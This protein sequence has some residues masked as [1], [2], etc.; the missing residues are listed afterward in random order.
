[1]VEYG[2]IIGDA[3]SFAVEPRRWIPLLVLDVVAFLL[4]FSYLMS[5]A[6]ALQQIIQGNL[7]GL[8]VASSIIGVVGFLVVL[9]VVWSLIRLYIVGALIHQSIKPKEYDKSW[10]V[11]KERYGS[12]LEVAVV[13][14]IISGVVS[15]VPYVGWIVSIIVSLMFFFSMP[16][17]IAKKVSFEDAL[18]ESYNIFRK[19]TVDVFV[20]WLL[21][22]IIGGIIV[23]V[24]MIPAMATIWSLMLPALM[25][26][27]ATGSKTGFEL[28]SVILMNGWTIVPAG[29]IYLIGSAYITVFSANAQTNFYLKMRK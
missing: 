11:S 13:I 6:L 21:L 26:M 12:I 19:K 29:I 1:M 3:L 9:F 15:I 16:T 23:M 8:L 2:K 7:S 22:A 24:F 28:F 27:Q 10:S 18:K 5:N 4:A 25:G 20:V 17:V 14:G